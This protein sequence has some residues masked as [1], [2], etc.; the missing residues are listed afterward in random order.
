MAPA[1][2]ASPLLRR[3]GLATRTE[4]V[5]I[6][7]DALRTAAK[8]AGGSLNDAY[9]AGLC[10]A[11]RRYHE[12]L[13]VAVDALPMA[14]PVSVRGPDDPAAGNHFTGVTL[15]API[16]QT[17]AGDRIR[18]V[19]TQMLS[20]REEPALGAFGAIAPV[21]SL[22][23]QPLLEAVTE[24]VAT[25]DVQASNVPGYIGDTYLAGAKVLRQYGLGPLPGVAMM[26]VMVSR[27]GL[28]TVTARYDLAS[29][30]D[31]ALFASCLREGFDEVL[32][33]AGRSA[34]RVVAASASDLSA[35][36]DPLERTT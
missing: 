22:L 8:A 15:A 10:G 23:P 24:A 36:S 28:C 7:F 19:R 20:R 30:S 31:P 6:D 29:V 35:G 9:L 18:A 1:A 13:G 25:P 32:A 12:R 14:V 16:G 3:R 4:A 21:L 27:A 5:D 17:D 34:P 11:L 33:L 26:V 2:K